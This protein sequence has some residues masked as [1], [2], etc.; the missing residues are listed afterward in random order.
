M[1]EKKQ[2]KKSFRPLFIGL[3]VIAA[4]VFTFSIIDRGGANSTTYEVS[5][6]SPVIILT[7]S[8]FDETIADGVVLV[9][10]WA[11]WCPP[12][13][14]QGPIIEELAAELSHKA[15][16][17]KLDVDD[18]SNI[19][20]RFGVRNIPTL[21]IFKDGEVVERFVGVQQKETLKLAI[22]QHL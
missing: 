8:S 1:K 7:D 19:A 10:F 5:E 14:I 13:R 4:A 2:N 16:I 15:S 18:Y 3:A 9:D 20:S 21:L 6:D 12:C 11:T 17:S 22:N